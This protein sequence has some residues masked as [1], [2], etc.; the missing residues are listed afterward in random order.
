MR[1]VP[2][3]APDE[4][5]VW[6]VPAAVADWVA[7]LLDEAERTQA[8][9]FV[10]DRARMLYAAA[11]GAL[12]VIL[13]RCLGRGPDDLRFD[14]G[15]DGKPFLVGD[16]TI[17]FNLSHS[18]ALAAVAVARERE[19]GIDVEVRREVKGADGVARRIMTPAERARY[20]AL[21]VAERPEFLL[22]VWA[23]KEALVKASGEGIRTSLQTLSSEPTP[24]D[25]FG[26]V[27]LDVPGHAAALA[28]EG[29]DWRWVVQRFDPD[30]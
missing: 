25:R 29:H 16:R 23:R 18:G 21:D 14:A 1:R 5:R 4:V 24:A 3:S 27:D 8:E 10:V 13:G 17:R 30:D 7:P 26:V 6:L 2:D 11:H 20:E 12:R 15:A 9:R 22:W 19:V 28:A